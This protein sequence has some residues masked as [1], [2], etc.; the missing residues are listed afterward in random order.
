MRHTLCGLSR[1]TDRAAAEG[2]W[3]LTG[4]VTWNER[5][6]S[7]PVSDW[8]KAGVLS[9]PVTLILYRCRNGAEDE[10]KL[11]GEDKRLLR[12][13]CEECLVDA[14][15]PPPDRVEVY[16][17]QES[18]RDWVPEW[19]LERTRALKSSS[20]TG[21]CFYLERGVF[22]EIIADAGIW[23]SAACFSSGVFSCALGTVTGPF[24]SLSSS[25]EKAHA[26]PLVHFPCW[27]W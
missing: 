5:P 19:K 2:G 6:C 16:G 20:Q 1:P 7:P 18:S 9:D 3:G 24:R 12:G 11:R 8:I 17:L 25:C 23:A 27:Y 14:M 26:S 21:D 10:R 4:S 15:A 22:N 13:G